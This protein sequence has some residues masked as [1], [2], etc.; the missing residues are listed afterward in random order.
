[1]KT[2]I[3]RI[4]REVEKK[5]TDMATWKA[6]Q[7]FWASTQEW[8]SEL[9]AMTLDRVRLLEARMDREHGWRR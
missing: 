9:L 4:H 5:T 6:V 1:M 7:D 2:L 3:S 8:P